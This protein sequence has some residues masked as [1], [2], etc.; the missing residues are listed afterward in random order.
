MSNKGFFKISQQPY[1]E[2]GT[3]KINDLFFEGK[4]T[5]ISNVRSMWTTHLPKEPNRKYTAIVDKV[6]SNS[7]RQQNIQLPAW[8][9]LSLKKLIAQSAN[10]ILPVLSIG[11]FEDCSQII[12]KRKL[13]SSDMMGNERKKTSIKVK[14]LQVKDYCTVF[15]TEHIQGV[16]MS[17]LQTSESAE[18]LEIEPKDYALL[19]LHTIPIF[20]EMKKLK[21][22][23]QSLGW[24]DF[25]LVEQKTGGGMKEVYNVKIPLY[26]DKY[27]V[28]LIPSGMALHPTF[29]LNVGERNRLGI[30]RIDFALKFLFDNPVI[31]RLKNELPNKTVYNQR[32]EKAKNE[33]VNS[34]YYRFITEHMGEHSLSTTFKY[35]FPVLFPASYAELLNTKEESM[36]IYFVRASDFLFIAM[37]SEKYP[38]LFVY[39][40]KRYEISYTISSPVG[41]SLSGTSLSFLPSLS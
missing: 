30:E 26:K 22:H 28:K 35:I 21:I 15:I 16:A 11:M 14:Q 29:E 37:L 32:I 6:N 34:F 25:A 36:D 20:E 19:L 5:K 2:E 9:L 27:E 18:E 7:F 12:D 39:L 3:I 1:R 4:A 13:T 33:F 8:R 24:R 23:Y 17:V 10:T 38:E 31:E 40:L 41:P